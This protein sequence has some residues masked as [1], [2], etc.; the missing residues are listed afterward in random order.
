LVVVA[1]SLI[2]RCAQR[3]KEEE[4]EEE[5]EE[6]EEEEK[7]EILVVKIKVAPRNLTPPISRE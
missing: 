6:E 3:K 7:L 2:S 5:E 1:C 4:G